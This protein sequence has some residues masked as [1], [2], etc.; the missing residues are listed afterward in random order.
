M[1]FVRSDWARQEHPHH[2]HQHIQNKITPIT[3]KIIQL[4]CKSFCIH[5]STPK[6]SLKV[7]IVTFSHPSQPTQKQRPQSNPCNLFLS[8]SSLIGLLLRPLLTL[9][10]VSGL[11][12][13]IPQLSVGTT[14][15][16]LR[17]ITLLDLRDTSLSIDDWQ[18]KLDARDDVL[19]SLD[20]LLGSIALLV[21]TQLAGEE[22]QTSV[23][24][25]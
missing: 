7:A 21:L 24:F 1:T 19:D 15:D 5:E 8:S 9:A 3:D 20:I 23:V 4:I 16:R 6:Q 2:H 22:D 18:T 13:D 10:K 14:L 12:S 11:T 25:L 17:H